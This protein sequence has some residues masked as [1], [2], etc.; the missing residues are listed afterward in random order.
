MSKY[1]YDINS[2]TWRGMWAM[3]QH[4]CYWDLSWIWYHDSRWF[5]AGY[6]WY[7]GPLWWINIGP[8]H[9]SLAA[10]NDTGDPE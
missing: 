9:L 8:I 5:S 1:D 10:I 3:A 7:D 4:R 6:T 2:W